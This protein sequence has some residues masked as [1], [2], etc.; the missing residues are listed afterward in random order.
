MQ[1]EVKIKFSPKEWKYYY[2]CIRIHCSNDKTLLVPIHAYPVISVK[3]LLPEMTFPVTPLHKRYTPTT[4]T[5]Y[6]RPLL[7]PTTHT[8]YSH[9][10]LTPTTHAHHSRPLLT[11]TTH[12]HYSRPLL[13]PTT[14]AHYSRPL[15]T[16]T[17]HAHYSRPLLTPTTHAHYSR[18]LLT[19]T[20]HA[21]HSRP[22]LTP[23]T[24][25]VL[26]TP[27]CPYISQLQ[28]VIYTVDRCTSGVSV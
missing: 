21:H 3:Q 16:P 13:T 15:L 14:H 9:P 28:E 6:S 18:P 10:L 7:T 19:P 1:L 24:L 2:D 8:H 12:T 27:I 22:L 17:T 23:T 26:V 25:P 4:H 11:P 5:H 20:T